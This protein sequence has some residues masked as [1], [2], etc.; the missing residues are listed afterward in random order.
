MVS[1]ALKITTDDSIYIAPENE[2]TLLEKVIRY[3]NAKQAEK[4][5]AQVSLF[6]GDSNVATPLPSVAVCEPFSEMEKLKI[7]KDV[8]GFY[9]SG[10]PLNQFEVELDSFCKPISDIKKFPNQ[11][12][13]IGGIVNGVRNGQTKNGKPFA[14]LSI[15][16]YNSSV[17]LFLMGEKY[18]NH[19]QYLRPGEFLFVT[20]KVELNW[21]KKKEIRENPQLNPTP[22]DWELQ[23]GAISLLS[24]LREKRAKGIKVSINA[25][26]VDQDMIDT[27][28][29][30]AKE[31]E[32]NTE[33]R[34]QLVEESENISVE[35]LSR[36]IKV[37][38]NS[39]L[40]RT[41][42]KHAKSAQLITN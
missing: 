4:D 12:I 14:I 24:E 34:I 18:M 27:I 32:G 26:D 35:L 15:E 36:R 16:D 29:K 40:I 10:H 7:E 30:L 41:L 6:G 17:E 1:I 11:D 23:V 21:R 31:H 2:Q 13:S 38:P 19:A 25:R 22:E 33:L 39:V 3:A 28:M 9:I 37:D 20:G 42:K 5:A 8:V